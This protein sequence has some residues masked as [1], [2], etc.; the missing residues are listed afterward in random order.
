MH[1]LLWCLWK[2]VSRLVY[3]MIACD[4]VSLTHY[5]KCICSLI[6]QL[7]YVSS[8][9]TPELRNY[10]SSQCTINCCMHGRCS[11]SEEICNIIWKVLLHGK[12]FCVLFHYTYWYV[13]DL[14]CKR[15]S[16]RLINCTHLA[17]TNLTCE[18]INLKFGQL[19][20]TPK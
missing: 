11:S 6:K 8:T 18:F 3:F 14:T 15:E 2:V 19:I 10:I 20:A 16:Y 7:W 9:P 17:N 13:C 1:W 5:I 4:L 12:M